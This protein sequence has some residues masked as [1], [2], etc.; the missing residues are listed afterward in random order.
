[1]VHILI[2]IESGLQM[3]ADSVP[4]L[5]LPNRTLVQIYFELGN[6]HL[7]YDHDQKNQHNFVETGTYPNGN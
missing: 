2:I 3:N 7:R 6:F 5:V 1:M 4:I